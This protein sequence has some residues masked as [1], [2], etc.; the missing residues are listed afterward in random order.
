M[1]RK[2]LFHGA[3][4]AVL[5]AMLCAVS[6]LFVGCGGEEEQAPAPNKA[7]PGAPV[8]PEQ[9]AAEVAPV[10]EVLG[11]DAPVTLPV[12]RLMPESAVIA[13]AVPSISSL[14]ETG[15]TLAKRYVPPEQ[16]DAA[17]AEW[18]S[19]A[20][21]ELGAP[22][23]KTPMDIARQRGF[24][25]DAPVALFAD[26]EQVAAAVEKAAA[27]VEARKAEMPTPAPEAAPDVATPPAAPDVATPPAAPDAATPP[28]AP[29]AATPP[30]APP[31]TPDATTGPETPKASVEQ[32]A[33]PPAGPDFDEM[34]REEMMKAL[35]EQPPAW[36]A[37]WRV[38]DS[39]AA[40]KSA[41][42]F[43]T[44]YLDTEQP[45]GDEETLTV[46][47]VTVH[48]FRNG[49]FAYGIAGERMFAGTSAPMLQQS[50]ARLSKPAPIRYGTAALPSLR[51]DETA[52][53][54]RMDR[55][56]EYAKRLLP[57][58]AKLPQ[59]TAF[60]EIQRNA[61]ENWTQYY[62]GTDPV[63]VT[64]TTVPAEESKPPMVIARGMADISQHAGLA[65]L[66]AE[67]KPLRLSPLMPENTQLLIAQ[68]LTPRI[69]EEFRKQWLAAIPP[70]ARAEDQTASALT[71][72]NQALDIVNDEVV[73]GVFPSETGLPGVVLLLGLT[74]AEQAKTLIGGFVPTTVGEEYNGVQILNVAYPIPMVT[75]RLAYV[76]N[77]LVA[78]TDIPAMKS[79]I[80]RL[81]G[82]T[83]PALFAS[84]DPPVDPTVPR[85]SLVVIKSQLLTDVVV[86]L[87]AFAGGL[88]Q[89]QQPVDT[90][91][92]V[93]RELRATCEVKQ[94]LYE[95]SVTI[96]LK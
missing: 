65:E 90:V 10:E 8:A 39:E 91:T 6:V 83:P 28:A 50:L 94:N 66:L 93:L 38:V 53:L 84:L 58:L 82:K 81:Q 62:T 55:L 95:T 5:L 45:L 56:T 26:M 23:A 42:D 47:G 69:K 25:P 31:A 76:D 1:K 43:A 57:V 70:E 16:V 35:R 20:A 96:Y 19:K 11:P 34:F 36:V 15:T 86:P 12:L 60:S 41:K 67:T 33:V 77:N 21:E 29:D 9:P 3:V 73:L 37:V 75:I 40:E 13:A 59:N 54:N 88:G 87:S 63:V 68:Q 71:V 24:D 48:S 80:D 17:V 7:E 18:M 72:V 46:E 27:A 44:E 78:A 74:N 22:E 52:I 64:L 85:Q 61:L 51:R 89:A 92:K 30:A 79:I 32:K 49:R 4:L 14:Y 2:N